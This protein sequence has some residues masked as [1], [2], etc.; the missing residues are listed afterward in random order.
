M[1]CYIN[2]Q[3]NLSNSWVSDNSLRLFCNAA[4]CKH[5]NIHSMTIEKNSA[6]FTYHSI[7]NHSV[8]RRSFDRLLKGMES[9]WRQWRSWRRKRWLPITFHKP[10]QLLY[11]ERNYKS[12]KQNLER[13]NTAS[14]KDTHTSKRLIQRRLTKLIITKAKTINKL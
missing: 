3:R 12:E 5:N 2:C 4:Q 13:S 6:Y 7:N 11:K 1:R 14:S 10:A 8:T 9:V